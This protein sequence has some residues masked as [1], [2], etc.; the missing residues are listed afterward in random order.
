V[1]HG[2]CWAWALGETPVELRAGDIVVFPPGDPHMLASARKARRSRSRA[3]PAS[4]GPL[5]TVSRHHGR[6]CEPIGPGRLRVLACD[7]QPFNRLL[8]ALP[9]VLHTTGTAGTLG[10]LFGFALAEAREA[11]VGSESVLSLLSEL[12]FV[13][14]VRSYIRTLPPERTG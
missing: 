4:E 7:A 8:A 1:T 11:T 5:S 2:R 13:E 12:M 14:V 3:L 10:T 6:E 9:R